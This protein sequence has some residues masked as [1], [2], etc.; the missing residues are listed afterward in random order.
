MIFLV[1]IQEMFK[2]KS[3]QELFGFSHADS[4]KFLDDRIGA[5]NNI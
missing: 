5:R 4:D 1:M 3:A 2:L